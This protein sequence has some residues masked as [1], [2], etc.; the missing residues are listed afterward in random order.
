MSSMILLTSCHPGDHSKSAGRRRLV[1]TGHS[2]RRLGR[3]ATRVN[4]P[5]DPAQVRG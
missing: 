2:D 1:P 4:G 3:S 5:M